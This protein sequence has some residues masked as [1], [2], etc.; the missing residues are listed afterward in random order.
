MDTIQEIVTDEQ[1]DAIWGNANFGSMS[2]RDV[3]RETLWK[4]LGGFCSGYT[5]KQIV[6]ELKLVYANK[7][8][9]TKRGRRYLC[10]AM[11][12][13]LNPNKQ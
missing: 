8:E 13:L 2:K 4:C 1:L 11:E 5:A 9:L 12:P 6:I 3:I 7:W 10:L